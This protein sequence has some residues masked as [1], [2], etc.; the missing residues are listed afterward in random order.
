MC[1][2]VSPRIG[3][4]HDHD[5]PAAGLVPSGGLPLIAERRALAAASAADWP[6]QREP[7]LT[8]SAR[9]R[10]DLGEAGIENDPG[11]ATEQL[12]DRSPGRVANW[13]YFA[14]LP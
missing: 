14:A 10:A 12:L 2:P 3:F 5:P 4:Q 11:S 6:R 7:L 1:P 8:P 13:D 9:G